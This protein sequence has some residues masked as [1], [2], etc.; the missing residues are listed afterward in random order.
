M[1]IDILNSLDYQMNRVGQVW[2]LNWTDQK[3]VK[4]I[5]LLL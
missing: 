3:K 1:Y 5:A 4:K 2:Y